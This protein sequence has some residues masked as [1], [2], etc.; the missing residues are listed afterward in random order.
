M[1]TSVA[2]MM[3]EKISGKRLFFGEYNN[4]YCVML[5]EKVLSKM[6]LEEYKNLL[7]KRGDFRRQECLA[8]L[9][10]M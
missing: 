3:K 1:T 10:I 5:L 2:D 9:T 4:V 8:L 7:G 6:L